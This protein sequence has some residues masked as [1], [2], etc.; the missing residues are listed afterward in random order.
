MHDRPDHH[1]MNDDAALAA[2]LRALPA[3]SPPLGAWPLLALRAR[4]RRGA[5]KATWFALPAALAAVLAL[6]LAWPHSP[7]RAS[8]PLPAQVAHAGHAA[9]GTTVGASLAALQASSAQWQAWAQKLDHEGAPLDGPTLATA[10]A[11]Q[12]R[13]GLIDLQLSAARNSA[14]AANLWRQ[15]IALLQQLG[16][17]HLQPSLVAEQSQD[18]TPRSIS[19]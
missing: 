4:R 5:R 3:Q 11:L 9:T 12:D 15:R 6:A 13:I 7:W 17:L 16:L 2:A 1:R 14:T 18:D 19:M 10:V 8:Q